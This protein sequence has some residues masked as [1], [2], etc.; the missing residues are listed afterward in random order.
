MV[1]YHLQAI[2]SIMPYE[3]RFDHLLPLLHSVKDIPGNVRA[4]TVMGGG[5]VLGHVTRWVIG[6]IGPPL[7]LASLY[8]CSVNPM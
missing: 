1:N 7:T 6:I 2:T 3:A 4:C 5:C 8:C